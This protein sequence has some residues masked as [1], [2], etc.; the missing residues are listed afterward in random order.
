MKAGMNDSFIDLNPGVKLLFYRNVIE[1]YRAWQLSNL[2]LLSK[3]KRI[4]KTEE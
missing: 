4:P 3:L 2:R 1:D